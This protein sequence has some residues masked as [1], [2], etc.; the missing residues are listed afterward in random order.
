MGLQLKVEGPTISEVSGVKEIMISG[1]QGNR[2]V[3][4]ERNEERH[5][6][7]QLYPLLSSHMVVGKCPLGSVYVLNKND[8]HS[9]ISM[10]DDVPYNLNIQYVL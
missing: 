10:Y 9:Y 6:L 2:V 3:G 7:I 5:I 1:R 4:N 8:V